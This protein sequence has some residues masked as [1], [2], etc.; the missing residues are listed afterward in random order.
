MDISAVV[1]R[2]FAAIEAGDVDALQAIYADDAGVWHNFTGVTQTKQEN[3]ARLSQARALAALKYEV[4]ERIVIADQVVQRHIV[5]TKPEGQVETS[6]H[7]ALF[8]AVRDGRIFHIHEYLDPAQS[9]LALGRAIA[10]AG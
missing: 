1:D 5:R 2:F 8:I 4:L 9:V 6:L 7:A 3:I 10:D